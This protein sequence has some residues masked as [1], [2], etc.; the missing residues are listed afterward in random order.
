[1]PSLWVSPQF[2]AELFS[3]DRYRQSTVAQSGDRR[4]AWGLPLNA[5]WGLSRLGIWYQGRLNKIKDLEASVRTYEYR[6]RYELEPEIERLK[7]NYGNAV[8]SGPER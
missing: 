4:G 1:V 3:R 2:A 7:N 5:L 6:V 8:D